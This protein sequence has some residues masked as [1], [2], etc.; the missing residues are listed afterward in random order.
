MMNVGGLVLTKEKIKIYV[1]ANTRNC[2]KKAEIRDYM[3]IYTWY[4]I[5]A[6]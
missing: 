3:H 4:L 6:V 2:C 1:A 5:C